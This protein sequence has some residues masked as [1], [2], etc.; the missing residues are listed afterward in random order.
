MNLELELCII[1]K[2]TSNN[3]FLC[4]NFY[5]VINKELLMKILINYR[6]HSIKYALL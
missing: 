4:K 6:M 1:S 3:F 2:V 5:F